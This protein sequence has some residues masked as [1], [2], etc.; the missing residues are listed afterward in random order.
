MMRRLCHYDETSENE[1]GQLIQRVD[2]LKTNE[3]ERCN[4]QII[5]KMH[6]RLETKWIARIARNFEPNS[7]AFERTNARQP[8]RQQ[9]KASAAAEV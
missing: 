3:G 9:Q 8:R 5:A 4:H 7:G 2:N 1:G 6:E